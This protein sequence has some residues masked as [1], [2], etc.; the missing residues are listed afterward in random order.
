MIRPAR[1]PTAGHP[2]NRARAGS[3][4]KYGGDGLLGYKRGIANLHLGG[5]YGDRSSGGIR[6]LEN[7]TTRGSTTSYVNSSGTTD[8]S[9]KYYGLRGGAELQFG[10]NDQVGLA[11]RLGVWDVHSTTDFSFDEW[12]EPGTGHHRYDSDGDATRKGTYYY[13]AADHQHDFNADGHKVQARVTLSRSDGETE[14]SAELRDSARA[15]TNG[16][17][18]S[19]QGPSQRLRL[20]LD[21]TLPLRETDKLEAGYQS[22]FE[23]SSGIDSVYQYNPA[24]DTYEFNPDFSHEVKG[25]RNIHSLYA[26][27]A[28]NWNRFGYQG[29]LR[30]EYGDRSIELVEQDTTYALTRWDYFP[31]I[32]LSCN[33]PAEQQVMVSYTRRIERPHRWMLDPSVTWQDAYNVRQGNPELRPEYVDSYE[34][35]HQVP[36][37]A[38]RLSTEA[39]YRRTTDL[40]QWVSLPYEEEENVFLQT[41]ENVGIDRAL[42]VEF[43][44]FLN[45]FKWWDVTLSGDVYDYRVEGTLYGN[46]FSRR[47]LS[48]STRLNTTFK[49]PTRT[50]LRLSGHY[51][52]PSAT[53]Q[54]Q[55]EGSYTVD[56]SASQSLFDR[57]LSL[58]L[59]VRDMLKTG[60]YESFSEGEGFSTRAHYIH[61]APVLTLSIKYNFNNFKLDQRMQD[62]EGAQMESGQGL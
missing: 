1:S 53:A 25:G 5:Y 46:D 20:K 37:G 52:G 33:L 48:W 13:V 39:F 10:P 23:S 40:H 51:S 38:N 49:F 4:S 59:Q 14:S 36:F 61:K 44:A 35:S 8:W 62:P 45:P 3:G 43:M 11:G 19:E 56:V 58:S 18:S 21:Y 32:H 26:L 7:Q 15:L 31:T 16:W 55:R 54:G 2:R 12:S 22:R 41:A 30:G 6:D 42:G 24:G 27:Y 34:V 47:S 29:G 9:V 17:T 57:R 28:G 50:R 60:K